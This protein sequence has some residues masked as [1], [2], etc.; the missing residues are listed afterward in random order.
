MNRLL[1]I[2]I[3]TFGLSFY[4]WHT[5]GLGSEPHV[6]WLLIGAIIFLFGLWF[7]LAPTHKTAIKG[8]L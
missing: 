6:L 1:A 8:K 7:V 5:L 4:G 2:F 3:S